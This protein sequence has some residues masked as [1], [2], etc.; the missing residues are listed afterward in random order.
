[1]RAFVI[2][3]VMLSAACAPVSGP[4]V[5]PSL[6]PS[7][8]RTA[9][10]PTAAAPSAATATPSPA[11]SC[12]DRVLA[13]MSEDQR[14]GQLFL[15]GLADDKLGPREID[16]ITTGHVG[17]VW[18][19][20]RTTAGVS[21][22]RAVSD[23]VQALVSRT[24]T[25]GVGLFVA[26]NQEGGV[27]QSLS[28]AGFSTIPSA[29]E[30]SAI[31]PT[32]LHVSARRWGDE[33]ATAGVDLD[34]APVVDVVPPGT[35]AQ[36]EPIGVL[37]RGYGHDAD[38]VAS[39]ASAFLAGMRD[40]GIATTAKHFPGLGN[41]RGNTDFT[42]AVVD[43]VLTADHP[44]LAAFAAAI[45]AGVPFVMVALATY[46]KI[47]PD[48]LAVFS[49]TIMRDLLRGKLGFD[50]VIVSDDLGATAAVAA[51][52]PAQ[53]GVDFIAAGGDLIISKTVDPALA[54]AGAIRA[55]AATDVAFKARVDDATRRV[56]RAKEQS[57]LLPC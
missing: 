49:P 20:E 18:F 11:P 54:M 2:A 38:T 5:S 1:M 53:R 16:A 42:S 21:A 8:T 30:Q 24:T 17:S 44:D 46:E 9:A 19:V 51:I 48:H 41:V 22:V 56:L 28:G 26:A 43:D 23:A 12:V 52:P 13:A 32:S 57:G 55:R 14:I 33:L 40:A 7:A 3:V 45:R 50:G 6:G 29:L 37:R 4:A 25:A 47:D 36:N 34:L 39:H 35:D 27:I 15:L 10:G 31:D